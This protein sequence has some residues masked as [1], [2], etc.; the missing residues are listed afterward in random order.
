MARVFGWIG[1]GLALGVGCGPAPLDLQPF[2]TGTVVRAG[3]GGAGSLDWIPR[4]VPAGET[5]PRVVAIQPASA[6]GERQ[7]LDLGVG[8][9]DAALR[10]TWP[11]G[12]APRVD[13]PLGLA[14]G[15]GDR[16]VLEGRLASAA[17]LPGEASGALLACQLLID[18]QGSGAWHLCWTSVTD[19]P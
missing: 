14:I 8:R 12:A 15:H 7:V 18:D 16:A 6:G 10:L 1:I 19:A 11:A 3:G 4:S 5:A 9:A 13:A 2:L 17:P